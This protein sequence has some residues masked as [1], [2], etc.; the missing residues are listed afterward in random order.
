MIT[1]EVNTKLSPRG[2]VTVRVS[3]TC[4]YS[5]AASSRPSTARLRICRSTAWRTRGAARSSA[6]GLRLMAS[7]LVT[8]VCSLPRAMPSLVV[9]IRKSGG[10]YSERKVVVGWL[11][12]CAMVWTS[13][14]QLGNGD[15]HVVGRIFADVDHPGVKNQIL[16]LDSHQGAFHQR[17]FVQVEGADLGGIGDHRVVESDGLG[18]LQALHGV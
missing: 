8:R 2:R 12:R 13:E 10:R 1:S 16:A 5:S 7:S 9:A 17:S 4:T 14:K 3:P 11:S 18:G 6:A 15:V